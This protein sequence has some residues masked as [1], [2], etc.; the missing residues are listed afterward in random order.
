MGDLFSLFFIHCP[1]FIFYPYCNIAE[2]VLI[3][4]DHTFIYL[5]GGVRY[6]LI[7]QFV[8]LLYDDCCLSNDS[9]FK[10]NRYLIQRHKRLNHAAIIQCVLFVDGENEI[11]FVTTN[12]TKETI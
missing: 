4:M 6:D 2:I 12:M 3:I 11:K 9:Y 8:R 7:C 1:F 5:P 10:F